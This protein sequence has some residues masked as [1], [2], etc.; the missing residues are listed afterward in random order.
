MDEREIAA[1]LLAK[2]QGGLILENQLTELGFSNAAVRHR[3][4]R[5]RW[6][7][8]CSGI[9][10]LAPEIDGFVTW[11]RAAT[12]ALPEAV[13]SH[14]AAA[15]LHGLTDVPRDRPTV[16]V[17]R[18]AAHEFSVVTVRRSADLRT[19][20]LT[21]IDSLPVTTVARTIVDLSAVLPPAALERALDAAVAARRVTHRE[22]RQVLEQVARRGKPGIGVLRELLDAR[23]M[24]PEMGHSELERRFV[25]LVREAGMAMPES[26][27]AVPWL[28][29][30]ERVD[31]AYPERRLAL[32]LDG[33]AWHT[34][35]AAWERDRRRDQLAAA[36]GWQVVRFTWRQVVDDPDGVVATLRSVIASRGRHAS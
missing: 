27:V 6:R 8:V 1:R 13:V 19:G 25:T 20:H 33:S 10:V 17:G 7:R 31:F 14:E 12:M 16:T 4:E 24:E 32:E 9:F 28:S 3:V 2:E 29:Q 11:L 15:Q 21:E 34:D 5:G 23:E 30:W 36:D 35:A 18:S 26:Q 22:I